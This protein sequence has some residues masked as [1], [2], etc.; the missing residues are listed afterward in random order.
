MAEYTLQ[1]SPIRTKSTGLY[2][3][4]PGYDE[5]EWTPVLKFGGANTG[6]T[7]SVGTPYGNYTQIGDLFFLTGVFILTAK[8]SSTGAAT[9]SGFRPV[10]V[11][12]A[13]TLFNAVVQWGGMGANFINVGVYID[14]AGDVLNI[15]GLAAAGADSPLLVLDESDFLDTSTLYFNVIL[16][17]RFNR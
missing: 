11:N 15:Y 17:K 10:D 12:S 4:V 7:H 2:S 6:M 16:R 5:G 3:L 8:G 1:P 13:F 14:D 9:I